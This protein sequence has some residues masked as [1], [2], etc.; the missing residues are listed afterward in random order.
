LARS[1]C[2]RLWFPGISRT[3]TLRIEANPPEPVVVAYP[4]DCV[5]LLT[6]LTL[7]QAASSR[8]ECRQQLPK[9]VDNCECSGSLIAFTFISNTPRK[10]APAVKDLSSEPALS[11]NT[12]VCAK[13]QVTVQ[14]TKWKEVTFTIRDDSN[15]TSKTITQWQTEAPLKLELRSTSPSYLVPSFESSLVSRR[16]KLDL[17]VRM[18]NPR[19]CTFHLTLPLQILYRTD[20]VRTSGDITE[21]ECPP[22]FA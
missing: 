18:T 11:R 12:H 10:N 19:R 20:G 3:R 2:R 4:T 22:Y 17:Q 15:D 14:F 6:C 9:D 16:H 1:S 5:S 8:R 7:T 21:I 13:A